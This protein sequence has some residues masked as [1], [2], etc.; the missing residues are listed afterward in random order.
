LA[1]W[2]EDEFNNRG[3]FS[4]YFLKSR[5]PDAR[6]FPVWN[7]D[8]R[9]LHQSLSKILADVGH[10]QQLTTKDMH[11][12]LVKPTLAA[13]GFKLDA[14]RKDDEADFLL[15][16]A[17]A[18][19][20]APPVAALLVYPWDRPLDRQDDLDRD[21]ADHVPGIRVVGALEK[22]QVPW[23]VLTNGKDWRLYCA[24]AHSRA[25]NYYEV[26]HGSVAAVEQVVSGDCRREPRTQRPSVQRGTVLLGS[27]A[28][29]FWI[30]IAR[31]APTGPA[32]R[33]GIS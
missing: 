6:A 2:S 5:L 3:L 22:Q 15:R 7:T 12:K 33:N 10:V 14:L 25:S 23:A 31:S 27:C 19:S 17:D 30:I 1:E 28:R 11:A 18:S 29:R 8:L 32:L 9:P 16:P 24:A 20:D 21:R 26:R 13:L 4:D